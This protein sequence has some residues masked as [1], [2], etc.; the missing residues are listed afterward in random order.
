MSGAHPADPIAEAFE[1]HRVRLT[2]VAYRVL[3][4]HADAEDA[5]QEAWLRLSRQ[6]AGAID[7]LGGWLTTVVGRISL[8]VLRSGRTR[9]TVPLDDQLSALTVTLDD[10]PTP[11]ERVAL[12]DSVGVALL[13]VLDSLRPDERL[14]FVLHDVFAVSHAEIGTILGRSTDATKMLTSRA[15]RK[16]QAVRHA[17]SDRQHRREV[18]GAFL[19][20]AREGRFERLL[21]VLHPEVEFTVHTPGGRFVTIGATEVAGR[22]RVAGSAARG[23]A[24]TV[25]GRPG[26]IAWNEDGTPLSVLAFTVADGRI[27]EITAVVDPAELARMDLP[28]PV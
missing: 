20:A 8:D 19:A 23:H 11:E 28:S 13:T 9:P 17:E 10:G 1:V 3:G 27:T 25:N 6:D 4:S 15:R 16:V 26:V 5:V 21:E 12:G 7:N 14:A 22:A 24:A 2:A 18:V